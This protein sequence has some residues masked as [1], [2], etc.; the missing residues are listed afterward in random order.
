MECR[1]LGIALPDV[2]YFT[3]ASV[4]AQRIFD[5]IDRIPLIDGEDTK[6]LVLDEIRGELEFEHVKFTYPSR[7]DT[8]VL[9]DFN[10]KVEAGQTVALVGAS[11]SG[12]S[13]A[14]SLV[15]RFYDA[16]DGVVKI[17]GVDVRTLHLKWIRGNM[18]LVS[19]D[20]AL[21]GTSIKENIM[22]GKLDAT[23]E[24]VT[25]AAMA[26]NAHNFIRQLPEG[27]ETK[28]ISSFEEVKFVFS[29]YHEEV[30]KAKF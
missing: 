5:R 22:F 11:G 16:D 13:T 12:K 9:K 27:Y 19:Q 20:H 1:S 14:I 7:P 3:E 17:D 15:Q 18:G 6:G 23:M 8:I 4:A 29:D 30:I 28:V 10:L 25:A 2:K 26:A 24:E 21:F